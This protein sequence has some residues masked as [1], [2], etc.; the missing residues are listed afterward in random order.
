VAV[1]FAE[2]GH[3]GAAGFEYPQAEQAQHR[4]EREVV[5]VGG[6]SGG[7]EQGFEPQVG[8]PEGGRLRQYG[9]PADVLGR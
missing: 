6:F 8:E 5:T 3:V 1:F 4:D 2:V 7:G 9:G